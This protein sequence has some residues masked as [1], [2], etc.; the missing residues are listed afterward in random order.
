MAKRINSVVEIGMG[1]EPLGEKINATSTDY[2]RRLGAALNWYNYMHDEKKARAY[3][4]SHLK[5]IKAPS[6]IV[7]GAKT[8]HII[9]SYGWMAR[10]IDRNALLSDAHLERLERYL[11]SL[12]KEEVAPAAPAPVKKTRVPDAPAYMGE[13]D[14][15]IDDLLMDKPFDLAKFFE[16][17]DVPARGRKD[18]VELLEKYI[19]EFEEVRADP[20]LSEGFNRPVR[21]R[22]VIKTLREQIEKTPLRAP[23]VIV[24]AKKAKAPKMDAVKYMPEYNGH[25][26]VSPAK[27]VG[28]RKVWLYKPK[29]NELLVLM[30][31]SELSISG[32]TIIG[33]DEKASYMTRI[34]NAD[35][36]LPQLVKKNDK[37]LSTLK[38]KRYPA[39]GRLNDGTLILR[40]E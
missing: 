33:F 3:L 28:A 38:T 26:S 21:L 7:E 35:K 11:K 29:Y 39:T 25:A 24:R 36:V 2:D 32:T 17:H 4:L 6:K 37:V 13:V 18:V 12:V 16:L 9:T 27:I 30:A 19:K 23:R 22:R 1:S 8:G 20:E 10:M 5:R 14:G 34:R 31:G 15:A 40:V